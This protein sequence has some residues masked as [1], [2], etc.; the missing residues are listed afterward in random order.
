MCFS[1]TKYELKLLNSI[2]PMSKALAQECI[3]PKFEP[4]LVTEFYRT[5]SHISI[6]ANAIIKIK[7]VP[8]CW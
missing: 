1:N 4:K 6:Y 8:F 5:H 7:I 3:F 2:E